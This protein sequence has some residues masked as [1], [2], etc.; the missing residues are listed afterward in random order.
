MRKSRWTAFISHASE[1]K[2][3]VARPLANMLSERGVRVWVD[4]SEIRV[5]DSLR[6]KIDE[7]LSHSEFGVIVLS[8]SFLSKG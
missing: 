8:H 6:N 7:G 1:D 3:S 4:E 5:G 2:S